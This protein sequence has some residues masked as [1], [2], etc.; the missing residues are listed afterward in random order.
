MKFQE[1]ITLVINDFGKDILTNNSLMNILNDYNAFSEEKYMKN[2]VKLL[3]EK[4]HIEKIYKNSEND[5]CTIII[6]QISH[7]LYNEYGISKNVSYNVLNSFIQA[8]GLGSI[9]STDEDTNSKSSSF[10]IN[11]K[12]EKRLNAY[13]ELLGASYRECGNLLIQQGKLEDAINSY[14]LGANKGDS[15]CLVLLTKLFME[16]NQIAND[17]SA[18]DCC[19]RYFNSFLDVIGDGIPDISDIDEE[20][21]DMYAKGFYEIIPIAVQHN[22]TKLFHPNVEFFIIGALGTRI[23]GML[24]DEM[25]TIC[26]EL[27]KMNSKHELG[28]LK[29][30]D[31]PHFTS[32]QSQRES[33]IEFQ[34]YLRSLIEKIRK[35]NGQRMTLNR[36][37]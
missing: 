18:K 2:V 32:L 27:E 36:I 12:V 1:A 9:E 22:K 30:E 37:E 33:I 23:Y 26:N 28:L 16:N 6:N 14:K 31:Y 8:L 13:V 5:N 11:D 35:Y 10:T 19:N 29:M 21:I 4:N 25:E 7:E 24:T 17:N 15:Q 3:V 34:S 20:F